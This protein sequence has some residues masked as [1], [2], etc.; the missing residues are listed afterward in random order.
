MLT[1]TDQVGR[2]TISGN[3]K[4]WRKLTFALSGETAR[5]GPYRPK[6]LAKGQVIMA[7]REGAGVPVLAKYHAWRTELVRQQPVDVVIF[8][9]RG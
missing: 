3:N 2:V 8:H 1:T 6:L 4:I 9:Q 5:F 7:F